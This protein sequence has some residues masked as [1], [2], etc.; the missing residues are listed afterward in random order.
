MRSKAGFK[1]GEAFQ[2]AQDVFNFS[3]RLEKN[4]PLKNGVV[5]EKLQIS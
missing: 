4:D 2:N 1:Y 5:L 3:N